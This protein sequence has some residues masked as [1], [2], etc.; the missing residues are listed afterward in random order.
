MMILTFWV[1]NLSDDFFVDDSALLFW[2]LSG[3]SLA[4]AKG[5]E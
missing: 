4:L 2:L 5:S 3:A 1:R